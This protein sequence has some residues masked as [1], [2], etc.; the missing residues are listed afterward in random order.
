VNARDPTGADRERIALLGTLAAGVAH[1]INNPLTYV[2]ASLD[3]AIEE[4][5]ALVEAVPSLRPTLAT[6][7]EARDGA[8]RAWL[9]ARDV[10]MFS[11]REPGAVGPVDLKR[12]LD[13]TVRLARHDVSARATLVQE[14]VGVPPVMGS[15]VGLG[16]V[17]LNLVMNA[18]QAIPAGDP[19]AHRICIRGREE[20]GRVLVEVSDTGAGIAP[21]IM[22]RIFDPFFTTKPAGLGTG[23]GLSITHDIVGAH[24]GSIHVESEV[25]RGTT[26][27]V[28]LAA[29]PRE[30]VRTSRPPGRMGRVL[31]VDD[32]PLVAEA[33][34]Q[35]LAAE[36][37]V[38]VAATGTEALS[39][40]SR[41]GPFDAIFCD[42]MMPEMDG[43]RFYNEVSHVAGKVTEVIA[44]LSGGVDDAATE[45]F[46]ARTGRPV[47]E[48]PFDPEG[49]R[50][51]V[52]ERVRGP[53][54]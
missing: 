49:L 7:H 34:R 11:R 33:V 40:V 46:L 47:L 1:E 38:A 41:H 22:R 15:E 31:V 53:G 4:V 5:A 43:M 28:S 39:I 18:A 29:L 54:G 24:G 10:R 16:Q 14:Y 12:V 45:V 2:M 19:K 42:L 48:K 44:F 26:F 20:L 21:E 13:A 23:L 3:Q 35:A 8:E 30:S 50:E 51:Y 9:V 36:N 27:T 25:G 6:M 52:R 17:F 32:D 37:D